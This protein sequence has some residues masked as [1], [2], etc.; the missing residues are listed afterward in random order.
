MGCGPNSEWAQFFDS[1][2][3]FNYYFNS[4][5]IKHDNCY[6]FAKSTYCWDQAKCDRVFLNDMNEICATDHP[7]DPLCWERAGEAYWLVRWF[8]HN[9]WEG[10]WACNDYLNKGGEWI[11][12][13]YPLATAFIDSDFDGCPRHGT[14]EKPF[15]T[16]YQA[17]SGA[18]DV[19]V[20]GGTVEIEAGLYLERDP[21][22]VHGKDVTIEQ[23][24]GNVRIRALCDVGEF[25]CGPSC[26]TEGATCCSEEMGLCRATPEECEPDCQPGELECG[27]GCCPNASEK[28]C[29]ED[30]FCY[31]KT[32]NGEP[33][34]C[35]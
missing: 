34:H 20:E 11:C 24:N 13:E 9:N 25:K 17:F 7:L 21:L 6:C 33:A 4:A 32:V 14:P 8:G 29:C 22:I 1:I 28:Q 12:P 2:I 30:L 3:G 15:S 27:M 23:R 31:P 35:P 10:D 26:C 18:E 5:C 19:V 16:V